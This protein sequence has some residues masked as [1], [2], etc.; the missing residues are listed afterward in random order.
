MDPS[1]TP[2]LLRA[3]R[4]CRLAVSVDPVSRELYG[5]TVPVLDEKATL[6]RVALLFRGTG[7]YKLSQ[8]ERAAALEIVRGRFEERYQ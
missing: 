6:R 4:R 1:K 3:A 5:T 7:R 2:S 8:P